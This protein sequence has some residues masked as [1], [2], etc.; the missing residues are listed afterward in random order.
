MPGTV[1]GQKLG[2]G[3]GGE[4]EA[5]KSWHRVVERGGGSQPFE[6]GRRLYF[7]EWRGEGYGG[8]EGPRGAG[9]SPGQS[10]GT[11]LQGLPQAR[12]LLCIV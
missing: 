7:G 3:R 8:G 10:P 12:P 2:S 4:G 5:G 9:R 11:E 6:R 1:P